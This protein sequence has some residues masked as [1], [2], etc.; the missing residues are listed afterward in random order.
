MFDNNAPR[1]TREFILSKISEE[2]IFIKYLGIEPTDKGQFVNPKRDDDHPGCSFYVDSRGHWKFKDFAGGFNWDCFN[3][4]EY[5]W[6]C[7]FKEAL[8]RIAI[9]FNLIDG[10]KVVHNVPNRPK[11]PK[12]KIELRVKRRSWTKTDLE[13]WE[14]FGISENILYLGGVSPI[15]HAWFLEDGKLRTAYYHSKDDPAYVY[16][17]GTRDDEYTYK[18]YLPFRSRGKRFLQSTSTVIQ[19]YN[20][21][22]KEGTNL[23]YTKSYKDVLCLYQYAQEF[24]LW[25]V[26]PMSE[27]VIIT[28]E[29]FSD[30]YNRFD[31]Q[32]TLFDFDR[33]GI[34]LMRKYQS[35][36]RLPFYMFGKKYKLEG[37]KD[38]SDHRKLKGDYATRKLIETHLNKP[39][40]NGAVP[41]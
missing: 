22:P 18:I 20:I 34:T 10:Q 24:D 15:S 9:D 23:L 41:F 21:L 12:S 30:L 33:A 16:N 11:K 19:G 4:V 6:G 25:S 5:E 13:F 39:Q 29:Q 37:I 1:I 8:L 3:V 31:N 36:Y 14:S 35:I 28:T 7:D 26:A 40:Q 32:A 38:F 2:Q 17:F 27:T